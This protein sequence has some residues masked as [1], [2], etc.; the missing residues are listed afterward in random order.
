MTET[1][2]SGLGAALEREPLARGRPDVAPSIQPEA[3]APREDPRGPRSAA[4]VSGETSCCENGCRRTG[5]ICR[6]CV[7][8]LAFQ[9]WGAIARHDL[10]DSRCELCEH[11]GG[12]CYC[13]EHALDAIVEHRAL[14]RS[15]GHRIGE[16]PPVELTELLARRER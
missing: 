10:G 9:W 5:R 7:R 14:M 15:L 11:T 6:E 1:G 2:A 16:P 3:R 12:A 4:A 8:A 13:A